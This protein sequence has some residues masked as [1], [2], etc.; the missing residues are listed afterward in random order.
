VG[1]KQALQLPVSYLSRQHRD[2]P[3]DLK[4]GEGIRQ[5]ARTRAHPFSP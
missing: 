5:Q 4:I 3:D 2:P 1:H